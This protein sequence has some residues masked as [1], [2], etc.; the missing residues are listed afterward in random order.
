MEENKLNYVKQYVKT[1]CDFAQAVAGTPDGAELPT[2]D[3]DGAMADIDNDVELRVELDLFSEDDLA[4]VM[5]TTLLCRH[6]DH[7]RQAYRAAVVFE[8]ICQE[9]AAHLREAFKGRPESSG[10][11][12]W[13]E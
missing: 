3:V 4:R 12:I 11:V 5:L 6:C 8:G 1:Y 10:E 7:P 9:Q 2:L 13:D